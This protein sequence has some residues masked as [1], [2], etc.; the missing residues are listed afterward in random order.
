SGS[1]LFKLS[2]G[3]A[4]ATSIVADNARYL[5]DRDNWEINVAHTRSMRSVQLEPTSDKQHQ[6]A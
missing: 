3:N 6:V 2:R 4:I 5:R 1:V